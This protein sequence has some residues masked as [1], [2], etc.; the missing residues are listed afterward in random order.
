[1]NTQHTP[2][3]WYVA[4]TGNHQGLV[5]DERTGTNIAVTYDKAHAPII[6]AA[7]AMLAALKAGLACFRGF[8]ASPDWGLLDDE[9]RTAM[10]SAIAAATGS[11]TP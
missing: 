2:G 3:P 6:A 4:G 5:I 8:S 7:P 11:A 10:E 1:M 9:A